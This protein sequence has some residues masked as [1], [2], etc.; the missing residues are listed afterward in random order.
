MSKKRKT[1]R[2]QD[3]Q[4]PMHTHR[5]AR[6]HGPRMPHSFAQQMYESGQEAAQ[7]RHAPNL[8]LNT[9]RQTPSLPPPLAFLD[10][11]KQGRGPWNRQLRFEKSFRFLANTH[12]THESQVAS[13]P[14]SQSAK[15]MQ[16][17]SVCLSV[18]V[19]VVRGGRRLKT[20]R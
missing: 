5:T 15:V 16:S 1:A 19:S 6:T 7:T 8:A 9:L 13:T 12:H 3:R 10:L 4:K 18:W 2:Q 20:F 17:R 14:H 11:K